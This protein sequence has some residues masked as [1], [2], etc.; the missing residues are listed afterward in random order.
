MSEAPLVEG[1]V[2][3]SIDEVRSQFRSTKATKAA[4]PDG[5][6]A[7]LLK[8]CAD[9]LAPAFQPLFQS[10][11]DTGVVP[12]LWKSS[13]IIPVPKKPK[14]TE[15]NH[16]RPVALTPLPMKCLERIMLKNLQ[17][18]I[19][20]HLD[21]LQ[22]AY[23][24]GRGVEDAVATILHRVLKHLETPG[25]Y[26]RILF[27]DFSSAFNTMQ[28]HV[29][30]KKL[31]QLEVPTVIVQWIL[32]FLSDRRQRVRVVGGQEYGVTL[33][34]EL[35]TNTG[36]P[37]GCVLSP[38]LYI[39]YT[40]SCRCEGDQCSCSKF[41]DDSAILG[42]MS[43]AESER[44]YQATV[45]KFSVWCSEHHLQLNV[46]KTKE[47][48]I[49]PRR[50]NACPVQPVTIGQEQVEMVESIRYLGLI[51][52]S[53]LSFKDQVTSVQK[54]CQQRLH[55]LRRLRSFHLDPQLLHNL[56]RSIIEPLLTYCST[57]YHPSLSVTERNKLIKISSTA[58][59][60]IG[61]PVPPITEITD[62]A[63]LRKAH[64]VS[65]DSS[66]PLHAEFELLPSGRRYRSTKCKKAKFS[67]SFVPM[68]VNRLNAASSERS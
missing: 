23:R 33:S 56:Y 12:T 55:V 60:I 61:L 63:L 65:A 39:T 68:A 53:S 46:I 28:R 57:I 32:D 3:I 10:S 20:P 58:S 26:A 8:S 64:A 30:V 11:A 40:N 59:K 45:D 24:A 66:H 50:R 17:P 19:E 9:S 41:A 34:P 22:F 38:Y 27:A 43:D 49:D 36:A 54:K 7:R 16:Y 15:P 5:I 67:R 51:L 6:S 48:V 14:P 47:L 31:Q 62:K 35:T 21:P 13:I 4:G 44:A 1:S 18:F 42:L 25:H 2:T 52:D 37:Q 29:L